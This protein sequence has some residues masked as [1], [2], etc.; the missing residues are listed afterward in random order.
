MNPLRSTPKRKVI[1]KMATVFVLGTLMVAG[2]ADSGVDEKRADVDIPARY[3]PTQD[4]IISDEKFKELTA[5]EH[6]IAL[7]DYSDENDA[8]ELSEVPQNA[9]KPKPETKSP[10]KT[11]TKTS[12]STKKAPAKKP[13]AKKKIIHE[14]FKY[15]DLG[16]MISVGKKCQL[17][18]NEK[19]EY[20]AYGRIIENHLKDELKQTPSSAIPVLLSDNIF[21]MAEAPKVC[22]KWKTFD[23]ATRTKFWVWVFASIA[24]VESSC[25]WDVAEKWGVN[26][27]C[28]G[29]LQLEKN[30]K[31]RSHRGPNCARVSPTDIRK[32]YAN[33]RCGMDIMKAQLASKNKEDQ[34]IFD[35]PLYPGPGMRASSYWEKLR[36]V[37]GGQIGKLIRG[38]SPCGA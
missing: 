6:G 4:E 38:F 28:S 5:G 21:G 2:K 25:R 18:M 27:V 1:L 23:V 7:P 22:P 9:P 8:T 13:Q 24:A 16:G 35:K 11:T 20:D 34:F 26:D 37:N 17:F 32:P 30:Y 31:L 19:G 10:V 33:L 12:G 29:L 36:R 14:N 3:I 15:T